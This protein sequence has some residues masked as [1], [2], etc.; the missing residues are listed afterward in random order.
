MPGRTSSPG[1]RLIPA[2]MSGDPPR[3]RHRIARMMGGGGRT[4]VHGT[5]HRGDGGGS[6]AGGAFGPSWHTHA[7]AARKA[8]DSVPD[9]IGKGLVAGAVFWWAALVNVLVPP[10]K[11]TAS[12]NF[13]ATV[14]R[15][16]R[17]QPELQ[18]QNGRRVSV[19]IPV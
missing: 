15:P 11:P 9:V 13:G 12:S 6:L 1:S 19:N 17:R 18:A 10:P 4:A 3:A 14:T 8:V 16:H 2:F 5:R 7:R